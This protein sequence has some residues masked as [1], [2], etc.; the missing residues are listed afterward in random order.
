MAVYPEV[1]AGHGTPWTHHYYHDHH[2]HWRLNL[3]FLCI[4]KHF[5]SIKGITVFTLLDRLHSCLW[6]S[7]SLPLY[8]SVIQSSAIKIVCAVC[9]CVCVCVC[10]LSYLKM[11][12]ILDTKILLFKWPLIQFFTSAVSWIILQCVCVCEKNIDSSRTSV[13]L[14]LPFKF[15]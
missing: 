6:V 8:K 3:H 5:S 15:I 1:P 12:V 4:Y 14:P 13:M 11:F 2:C 7:E 10:P 9:V